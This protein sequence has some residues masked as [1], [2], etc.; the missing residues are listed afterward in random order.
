[1]TILAVDLFSGAGGM[2]LG[3]ISS[4][5][6]IV[7]AVDKDVSVKSTYQANFP[8]V[9]FFSTDIVKLQPQ[10]LSNNPVEIVLSGPPCQS[11]STSNQRTRNSDN[12]LNNLLY[13]PVRFIQALRPRLAIIENVAGLGIG[14]RRTY[15]DELLRR[16]RWL[17]YYTSVSMVS[18]NQVGIP[19][20]RNRLFVVASTRRSIEIALPRFVQPTVGDAIDDLPDIENGNDVDVLPYMRS[21][22][23]EYSCKLRGDLLEC[24]GHAVTKN[25]DNVIERFK[26]VSPGG[27]WK[28]IPLEMMENYKDVNRCHTG[29]YHRLTSTQPAKV[30]GNFRKNMLIHPLKDRGLSIREASRIQSFPDTF[31]F[32][33]SIGKRQQ[34][35]GN[36]VP[37]QMAANVIS[38]L[39]DKSF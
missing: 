6:E 10:Q 25:S 1:M 35:V 2:S 14:T 31:R 29:I 30:I 7:A 28:E 21:A 36:A 20:N 24:D 37:P 22:V 19:Q 18:G 11:F 17:G 13:E 33:G 8:S 9:K 27:N 32:V 4:G 5:V 3:A 16:L 39:I 26:K 12:P 23:S 34:Q 15:L 38:H